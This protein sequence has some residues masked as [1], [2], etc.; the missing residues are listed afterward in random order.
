MITRFFLKLPRK[1]FHSEVEW[2]KVAAAPLTQALLTL[3]QLLSQPEGPGKRVQM[4]VGRAPQGP[5][6]LL[7]CLSHCSSHKG[8][9]MPSWSLDSISVHCSLGLVPRLH[10]CPLFPWGPRLLPVYSPRSAISFQSLPQQRNLP[11][12]N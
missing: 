9:W 11:M 3:P 7:P 1:D 5:K 10:K 8:P 6:L 2:G 4:G 12:P